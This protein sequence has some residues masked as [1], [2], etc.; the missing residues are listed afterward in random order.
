[1]HASE[2]SVRSGDGVSIGFARIGNGPALVLVH[3]SLSDGD[4]WRKVVSLLAGR[5]T[6]YIMDRRGRGRSG[7][8]PEYSIEREYEDVATCDP[9]RGT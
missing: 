1:M 8:S 5:F 7:D 2:G 6:C 9:I 3:G 4:D